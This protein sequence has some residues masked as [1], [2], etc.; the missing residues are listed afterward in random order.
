[1]TCN[2]WNNSWNN[3]SKSNTKDGKD[4]PWGE[5]MNKVQTEAITKFQN[6]IQA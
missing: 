3:L 6:Q 5:F 4:E 1:M 2:P